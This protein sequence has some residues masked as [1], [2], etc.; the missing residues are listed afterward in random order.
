MNHNYTLWRL[1]CNRHRTLGGATCLSFVIQAKACSLSLQSVWS[2]TISALDGTS[3]MIGYGLAKAAV[4]QLT[5]SLSDPQAAG[6]PEGTTVLAILPITL[7]T[8]MNRKWMSKADFS[9]WTSL[10]FVADLLHKWT[11]DKGDRPPSGSLLKLTTLG[12][13]TNIHKY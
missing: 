11:T 5:K 7:D 6:L 8:P 13:Q 10:T 9:T 4:H 1:E 3:G 12:S 2:S